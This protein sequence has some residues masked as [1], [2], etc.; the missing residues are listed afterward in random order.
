MSRGILIIFISIS[1]FSAWIWK[2]HQEKYL[3][4]LSQ[5]DFIQEFDKN[6]I[7]MPKQIFSIED[8]NHHFREHLVEVKNFDISKTEVTV[9]QYRKCVE[10]GVC[11]VP[12]DNHFSK[13]CNWGHK[14]RDQH[15]INCVDWGQARTFAKWVGGDLPSEAQWEYAKR[16]GGQDIEYPWGD[17]MPTCEISNIFYAC[18]RQTI[19]VCSKPKGNTKQGLC[20][21]IGNVWEWLLDEYHDS[22]NNA[23]TDGTAWCSDVACS[24]PSA[25]RVNRGNGWNNDD[26]HLIANNREYDI[27]QGRYSNLGFRVV[28]NVKSH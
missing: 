19:P 4:E 2:K 5:K 13:Y 18:H 21:M 28:K 22:F 16:S 9:A 12:D 3:I 14:D 25:F 10:A 17:D 15:P 26:W 20:D 8:Y 23:P 1:L 7:K 24:H 27:H 6:M 11:S